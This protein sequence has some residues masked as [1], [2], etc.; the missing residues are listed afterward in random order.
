MSKVKGLLIRTDG[1]AEFKT[2]EDELNTYY[3]ELNCDCIDIVTRF[4][5]DEEFVITCDDEGLLK[6]PVPSITV[7][8][9][10]GE[11]MIV[12]NVFI[13]RRNGPEMASLTDED[14]KLLRKNI[15][16]LV[17]NGQCKMVFVCGYRSAHP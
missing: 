2:V 16:I 15:A 12:G 8:D 3:T 1:T 6:E 5:G 9:T 11:P 17:V 14:I 7:F 4:I 13:C 10:D